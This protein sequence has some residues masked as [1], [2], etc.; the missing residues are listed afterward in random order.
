MNCKVLEVNVD[1]Y[2]HGGVYQLVTEWV[3]TFPENIK[4]DIAALEPFEDPE[5]ITTLK[6]QN[7]DVFYVGADINKIK[8]QKIIYNNIKALIEREHYDVVHL[9]SDVAHKI[10][11]SGL[12]AKRSGVKKII[13]H[14]HANGVE[15]GHKKLRVLFH[16]MCAGMLKKVPA[17]HIA[18]SKEAGQWMFPGDDSFIVMPNG[19]D[20]DRYRF[21]GS[22]R[23]KVKAELGFTDSLV[24]GF[25]GRFREPKNPMYLLDILENVVKTVPEARLLCIGEGDMKEEFER[26]AA[27]RGLSRYIVTMG[28]VDNL[29]DYYQAMDIML[30]PSVFEGFGLVAVEAQASGTPVLASE[31]IPAITKISDLITYLPIGADDAA[32]WSEEV[33]KLKGYIKKDVSDELSWEYDIRKMNGELINIYT[34]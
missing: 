11:V 9:H 20:Y 32:L 22:V 27:Q 3:R 28:V 6:S 2:L 25:A 19:V 18:T 23:E 33:T 17:V 16:R 5:H 21:D 7:C 10:L 13:F 26:A 8:K 24:L 29:Q 15:G 12:A 34:G 31:N 30:M 14:S 1:D 4:I